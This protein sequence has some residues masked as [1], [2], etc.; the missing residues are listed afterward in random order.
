MGQNNINCITVL[1]LKKNHLQNPILIHNSREK[2]K[3]K[4][5]PVPIAFNSNNQFVPYLSIISQLFNNQYHLVPVEILAT[6]YLIL[7]KI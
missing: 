2:E 5:N 6:F 3:G 4:E 7:E 1:S